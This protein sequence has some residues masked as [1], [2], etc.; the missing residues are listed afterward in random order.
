MRETHSHTAG[1]IF[2]KAY[3]MRHTSIK[4]LKRTEKTNGIP[5]KSKKNRRA[6]GSYQQ[7][8]NWKRRET[9]NNPLMQLFDL[10]RCLCC[11]RKIEGALTF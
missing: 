1:C 11:V 2:E 7:L 4:I 5:F 10:E 6:M 3:A 8:I 9:D